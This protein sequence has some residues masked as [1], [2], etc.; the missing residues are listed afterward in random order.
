LDIKVSKIDEVFNV[1]VDGIQISNVSDFQIKSS[2]D[3][4]TELCVKI[5][6]LA[7]VF[8]MSASLSEQM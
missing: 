4:S 6:G 2:A 3:G 5:N 7:S 8:E 1:E